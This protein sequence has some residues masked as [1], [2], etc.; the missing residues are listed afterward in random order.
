MA[1]T[2]GLTQHY[3]QLFEQVIFIASGPAIG[4]LSVTTVDIGG[5]LG[6]EVPRTNMNWAGK[7]VKRS[8][9]LFVA[10][11]LRFLRSPVF[12]VL[13]LCD[14]AELPWSGVLRAA[15]YRSKWSVL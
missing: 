2:R 5:F 6:L 12:A 15:P 10:S 3:E 4:S 11:R 7:I 8:L 13:Y 1:I 9:D 14:Q